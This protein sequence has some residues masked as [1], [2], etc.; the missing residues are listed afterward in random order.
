MPDKDER[1]LIRD[2]RRLRALA[3]PLRWELL[4]LI[5]AE[6]TAT[7]TRCAHVLDQS[8]ASCSYHLNM[9]AKYGF[10]EEAAGGEGRE[11]PWRVTSVN[12]DFRLYDLEQEGVLAG[13][14]AAGALVDREAALLKDRIRRHG[15]EPVEWQRTIGMISSNTFLTA[16]ELAAV[17]EELMAIVDRYRDRLTDPDLRPAGSREVRL[18]AAT[19]VA[20]ER[21]NP[22]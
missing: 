9:L 17:R 2:P 11:K 4:D 22:S 13:E 10:V 5:A 19:T 6:G 12:Q 1:E 20:P 18:F 15:L 14:A 16:D 21:P 8:V 3:H 7:A